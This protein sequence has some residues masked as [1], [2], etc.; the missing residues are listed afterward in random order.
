M[1]AIV[2]APAPR[3]VTELRSFLGLVNYYGN[4]LPDLATTLSPLYS[5]LQKQKRWTWGQRQKDAFKSVKDL[6]MSS[7]VLVHFDDSL[8]LVLACE[9]SPYGLGA[10]LSHRKP[11]GTEQLVGFSSRTLAKAEQTTPS[12]TRRL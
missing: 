5:L 2:D 1:K 7:R 11:D 3:N 4:F 10:V 12:W 9:T 6:L 8:P